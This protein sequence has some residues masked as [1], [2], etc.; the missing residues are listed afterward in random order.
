MGKLTD[1]GRIFYGA[2]IAGMGVQTVYVHD[3]PYMLMALV[4]FRAPVLLILAD[5]FGLVFILAGASVIFKKKIRPVTLL[6]GTLLLLIFCFYYI[7]YQLMENPNYTHLGEWDNAEKEWALSSG[8]FIIAGCFPEKGKMFFSGYCRK[9]SN[10]GLFS[11]P[12]L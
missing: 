1:M 6:L 9:G 11:L 12:S 5:I 8:A 7:P 2:A 4:N 10:R 3:L